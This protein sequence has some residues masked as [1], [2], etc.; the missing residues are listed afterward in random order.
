MW[1][2]FEDVRKVYGNIQRD[3][4]FDI[5]EKFGFPKKLVKL[6]KMCMERIKYKI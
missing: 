1:Q 6:A 4:V 5:M 2:V 3:S